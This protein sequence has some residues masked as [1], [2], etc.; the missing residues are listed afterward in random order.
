M[1]VDEIFLT[2]EYSP[3]FGIIWSAIIQSPNIAPSAKS[4][5]TLAHMST[6]EMPS[7]S[8]KSMQGI[9]ND[10]Y[11]IEVRLLSAFA[12]KVNAAEC[13][14]LADQHES[15]RRIVWRK[16]YRRLLYSL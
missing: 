3:G 2:P 10:A 4:A 11:H 8:S 5:I 7:T 16:A 9:S 13:S 1:R 14:R 12:V 15:I 6:A